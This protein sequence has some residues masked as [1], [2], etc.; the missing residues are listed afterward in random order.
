MTDRGLSP[1]DSPVRGCH[2]YT[3]ESGKN[4][5][6]CIAIKRLG[7]AV[8]VRSM[9]LIRGSCRRSLQMNILI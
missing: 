7:R 4:D 5:K 6:T 3:G 2:I 9:F 1:I 8:V